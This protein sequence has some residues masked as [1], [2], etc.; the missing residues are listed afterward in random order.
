MREILAK[1]PMEKL[2]GGKDNRDRL[3][4]RFYRHMVI[5]N[6]GLTKQA[7]EKML[8]A[9]K[10]EKEKRE[11]ENV[12]TRRWRIDNRDEKQ[13][14]SRTM[15]ENIKMMVE[16]LYC[17]QCHRTFK[18]KE[19]AESQK[20]NKH[21]FCYT[22]GNL[23]TV[24]KLDSNKTPTKTVS[25]TCTIC[26]N[27]TRNV[28]FACKE[29]LMKHMVLAHKSKFFI[30]Q[31]EKKKKEQHLEDNLIC[32]LR[33]KNCNH[34]AESLE[35]ALIHL[36]V[37]HKKLFRALQHD[38]LN[39]YK[40]IA[41][42]LFPEEYSKSSHQWD[43][44]S[45]GGAKAAKAVKRRLD[46][47]PVAGP[48]N[49]TPRVD[50]PVETL[51]AQKTQKLF[52][53]DVPNTNSD[54]SP[55]APSMTTDA[56]PEPTPSSSQQSSITTKQARNRM[57]KVECPVCGT[58][59]S[60]S[61]TL[62]NHLAVEHFR[63]VISQ[64]Y[65]PT[66]EDKEGHYPCPFPHC[67]HILMT[68]LNRIQHLGAVHN[69]S[70]KYLATPK[71][72]EAAKLEVER[73]KRSR[74]KDKGE[75]DQPPI[76]TIYMEGL[77][78]LF[79]KESNLTP[80][81]RSKKVKTVTLPLNEIKDMKDGMSD[82]SEDSTELNETVGDDDQEIS[83]WV[84]EK[85]EEGGCQKRNCTRCEHCGLTYHRGEHSHYPCEA[86]L[87]SLCFPSKELQAKHVAK[88]HTFADIY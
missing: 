4:I 72:L 73:G 36:G 87:C 17:R 35:D 63:E 1:I 14:S 10:G 5:N 58:L 38:K 81:S 31:I 41:R 2:S 8:Q 32:V 23:K 67:Q 44:G 71:V 3:V 30:D 18:D 40:H 59:V 24:L 33:E 68:D 28:V 52:K 61:R 51:S 86:R 39:D 9:K 27:G 83:L 77:H 56:P 7:V 34:R 84:G 85:C 80:Q 75:K 60:N 19:E 12:R 46:L 37:F 29:E 43:R 54:L 25:L 79:D 21:H 53:G 42:S 66:A 82:A 16:D 50:P 45:D 15:E 6:K 48:S 88:C 74:E 55:E 64:E 22:V 69:L 57:R 76:A 11:P 26:P 65:E 20:E 47:D 13:P 62:L 78:R 49:K 70:Q